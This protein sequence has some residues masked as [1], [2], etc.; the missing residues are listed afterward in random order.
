MGQCLKNRPVLPQPPLTPHPSARP[1][2]ADGGVAQPGQGS[3]GGGGRVLVWKR[4][5]SSSRGPRAA[6]GTR[7][8]TG[9]AKATV[10]EAVDQGVDTRRDVAQQVDERDGRA[11]QGSA[12]SR[13]IEGLPRVGAVHRQPT[14]E[15]E[16]DDHQQ[17]SHHA[18]LG[19]Q[20]GL[21]RLVAGSRPRSGCGQRGQLHSGPGAR[22]LHIAAIAVLA[23]QPGLQPATPV[24]QGNT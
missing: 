1:Q 8:E 4:P 7:V 22:E 5:G 3:D 23:R 12:R 13:A 16:H 9:L 14:Q 10:H 19:Q 11:R 15:E 24:L 20:L 21:G 6:S 18:L 17:H 2:R